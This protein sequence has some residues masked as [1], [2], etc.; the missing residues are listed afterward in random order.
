MLESLTALII[1]SFCLGTAAWLVFIFASKKGSFDD[2][3]DAKYRMLEDDDAP[4]PPTDKELADKKLE[5]RELA[6]KKLANRKPG[7]KK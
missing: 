5:D 1:L 6:N 4:L 2:M 7:E 3:E